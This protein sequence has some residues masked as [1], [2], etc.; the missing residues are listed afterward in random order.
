MSQRQ[1][2]CDRGNIQ[3]SGATFR[4]QGQRLRVR[5]Y[6]QEL[7]VTFMSQRQRTYG[8]CSIQES[9]ITFKSQG[10]HLGGVRGNIQELLMK[11]SVIYE[12]HPLSSIVIDFR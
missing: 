4:S 8:R 5:V 12:G 10:Q 2:T 3:E 11:S 9:G 6:I 1:C 7:W